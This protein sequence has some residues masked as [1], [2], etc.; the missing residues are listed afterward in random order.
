[1]NDDRHLD[2]VRR[3]ASRLRD[4]AQ[5][6]GE[7][8]SVRS[9]IDREF[10]VTNGL[11][12][13][14][15][16]ELRDLRAITRDPH[17]LPLLAAFND[18]LERAWLDEGGENVATPSD[19]V[20][21]ISLFNQLGSFARSLTGLIESGEATD[22]DVDA[23]VDSLFVGDRSYYSPD[24][25]M[26]IVQVAPS[27]D[28]GERR[29]LTAAMTRVEEHVAATQA[30]FP[31][32]TFGTAGDIAQEADEEEALGV[33]IVL[34]L[35][36]IG[37][38]L[39]EL[40]MVTSAFGALLVGL[41]IDFGIHLAS[42]YDE[43]LLTAA[44]REEAMTATLRT[45][46]PPVVIGAVTTALA[47][48]ALCL[49]QT[50]GFVQF[51]FVAGSG[52]VLVLLAF[53]AR[54]ADPARRGPVLRYRFLAP[55]GRS[56]AGR[57]FAIVLVAAVV[58]TVGAALLIPRLDYDYDMRRIGPQDTP[59]KRTEDRIMEAFGLTPFPSFASCETLEEARSLADA[60][61]LDD[62]AYE[63]Q[64]LEWNV[65]EIADIS[66]ASFGPGSRVVEKRDEMVARNGDAFLVAVYPTDAV[67][68]QD[69]LLRLDRA[70]NEISSRSRSPARS[71][72]RRGA[73]RCSSWA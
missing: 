19:E 72:E 55:L 30:D 31:D 50:K 73:P 2:A 58:A 18:D 68:T 25:E 20:E 37:V 28:L 63:V 35:G 7:L 4:D 34:D 32:L 47:F 61:A 15:A 40:N 43:E 16:D 42:R 29:R 39:G 51:G 5:L 52:V 45:T 38:T 65:I 46:L 36:L 23:T 9:R 57:A 60:A 62:L 14:E 8:R 49:S 12:L 17:L 6:S 70:M 59:S 11:L 26:L 3:V 67:N 21:I 48:Y 33:G 44:T 66:A 13:R 1:M 10:V 54:S 56:L 53:G 22:A 71:S 69:G 41:G 27:F 64:R 24:Y